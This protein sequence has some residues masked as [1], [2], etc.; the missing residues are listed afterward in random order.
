MVVI[1]DSE[2]IG[3]AE[4]DETAEQIQQILDLLP[5]DKTSAHEPSLWKWVHG[6]FLSGA[7]DDWKAM[8]R[9]EQAAQY[10]EWLREERD[11]E[12]S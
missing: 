9:Y 8:S 3:L 4:D 2:G 12:W 11:G 6:T 1:T 5:E 7:Y 10:I